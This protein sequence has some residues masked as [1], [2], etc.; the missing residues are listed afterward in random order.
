[1]SASA[2]PT[3]I[4]GRSDMA[5]CI[6]TGSC[7]SFGS[8]ATRPSVGAAA[9]ERVQTNRDRHARGAAR[10]FLIGSLSERDDELYRAA[11]W[12]DTGYRYPSEASGEHGTPARMRSSTLP[13][14]SVRCNAIAPVV[15]LAVMGS[16]AALGQVITDR[17]HHLRS[18][19]Q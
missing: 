7:R 1:M 6:L 14:M 8:G 12:D 19:E 4:A 9:A 18:G 11:P 16:A 3:V 13:R 15:C 2:W 5:E 17:A 10:R